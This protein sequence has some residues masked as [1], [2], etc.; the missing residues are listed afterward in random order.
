MPHSRYPG[1]KWERYDNQFGGTPLDGYDNND[2]SY[3]DDSCVSNVD[4]DSKRQVPED[5]KGALEFLLKR[6]WINFSP[7]SFQKH[8]QALEIVEK[9]PDKRKVAET[10]LDIYPGLKG[11]EIVST[12]V[13]HGCPRGEIVSYDRLR[14]LVIDSFDSFPKEERALKLVQFFEGPRL[15]NERLYAGF[16]EEALTKLIQLGDKRVGEQVL[17]VFHQDKIPLSDIYLCSGSLFPPVYCNGTKLIANA[18][19]RCADEKLKDPIF[20]EL[21]SYSKSKGLEESEL[22]MLNSKSFVLVS[23]LGPIGDSQTA[24]NIIKYFSEDYHSLFWGRFYGAAIK[25]VNEIAKREGMRDALDFILKTSQQRDIINSKNG[26]ENYKL[27]LA[28]TNSLERRELYYHGVE[29]DDELESFIPRHSEVIKH[30]QQLSGHPDIDMSSTAAFALTTLR[31][32]DSRVEEHPKVY[33]KANNALW[34]TYKNHPNKDKR[35][36]AREILGYSALG[37]WLRKHLKSN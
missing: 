31:G 32:I 2:N 12:D 4:E 3:D 29:R 9:E 14:E 10:F 35:V 1:G 13:S 33:E 27:G 7:N 5:L 21:D 20:E 22:N 37:G 25:T 26:E 17:Q 30:L 23:A 6:E 36:R 11:E 15:P 34:N 24:T 28:L 16:H 18:L 19:R 8:D